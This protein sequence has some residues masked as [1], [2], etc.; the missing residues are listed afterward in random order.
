VNEKLHQLLTQLRL[1]GMARALDREIQRVEKEASPASEVLH[2]LLIE[3]QDYRQDQS[4][5]SRL[6][7]AR[8]PWD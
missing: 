8:T 4:L 7:R 2:R 1:K 6:K 5:I 3:E